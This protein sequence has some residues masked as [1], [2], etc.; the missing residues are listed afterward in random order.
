MS[1]AC[2]VRDRR[3]VLSR[4][5]RVRPDR[6][7]RH[8]A[9]RR[10]ERQRRRAGTGR[11][12]GHAARGST[13]SR[14]APLSLAPT[15]CQ[16]PVRSTWADAG[17][18]TRRRDDALPR[19]VG[20]DRPW[21]W[22]LGFAHCLVILTTS[23]NRDSDPTCSR[24]VPLEYWRDQS[25]VGQI[26]RILDLRRDREPLLAIRPLVEIP[27]LGQHGVLAVG[28]AVLPQVSGAEVRGRRRAAIRRSGGAAARPRRDPPA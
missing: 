2:R 5:S 23:P 1:I 28:D 26:P 19:H 4:G 12:P 14:A 6:S 3:D 18:A 17:A 25:H 9:A 27:V 15:R 13:G 7:H 8:L 21:L 11:S 10:T 16:V 24:W 22:P 20:P